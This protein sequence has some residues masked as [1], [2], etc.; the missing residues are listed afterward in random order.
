M[1]KPLVETVAGLIGGSQKDAKVAVDAVTTA[2]AKLARDNDVRIIGFGTFHR[3]HRK[4]TT[5]RNP[6]TGEPIDI[7]ASS[8][9]AFRASKGA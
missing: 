8:R 6:Q 2:I 4:A 7:P 1:S 9:L 5:G 3:A